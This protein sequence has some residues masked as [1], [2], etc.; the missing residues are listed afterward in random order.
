LELISNEKSG[1]KTK[2]IDTDSKSAELQSA[3]NQPL[4]QEQALIPTSNTRELQI[5]QAE[6]MAEQ[7]ELAQEYAEKPTELDHETDDISTADISEVNATVSASVEETQEVSVAK[8]ECVV[9]QDE[10]VAGEMPMVEIEKIEAT[11][12]KHTEEEVNL[13]LLCLRKNKALLFGSARIM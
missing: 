6:I 10:E 5:D 9:L 13:Y 1:D 7:D 8:V 11:D 4:E 2:P 12:G 3:K